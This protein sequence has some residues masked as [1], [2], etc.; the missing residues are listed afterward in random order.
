MAETSR[1]NPVGI[2]ETGAKRV[3][4]SFGDPQTLLET[5]KP[6][7]WNNYRGLARGGRVTLTINGVP[8][9]DIDDRD[10]RRIVATRTAV[11][12][13]APPVVE[14]MAASCRS[15]AGGLLDL[16]HRR[17]AGFRNAEQRL[18]ERAAQV[19]AAGEG[20]R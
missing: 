5:V 11:G 19:A 7:E 18:V 16:A 9:S 4:G 13:A 2:H 20:R 6:G 12:G 17:R 8:I 15:D 10:P 14:E 1:W 3:T